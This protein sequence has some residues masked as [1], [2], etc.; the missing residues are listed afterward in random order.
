MAAADQA[1]IG[2]GIDKAAAVSHGS[3]AATGI[4]DVVG[5]IVGVALFGGSAGG[6]DTQLSVDDQ[7]HILGQVVGDQGGQADAQI[8]DIAVLQFF[9]AALGDKAFDLGLFHYFLSPSTM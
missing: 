3:N 1:E 8:D 4:D 7:L 9:G 6:N 5:I 2:S